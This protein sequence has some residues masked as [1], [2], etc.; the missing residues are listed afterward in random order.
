MWAIIKYKTNEFSV[1]KDSFKRILGDTPIFYNPKI[2]Y[3][4]YQNNKLKVYE[5][6]IL[7]NY[8]ICKHNKFNDNRII[9]LLKNSRGLSY[10]LNGFQLNQ[11]DIVK[12]VQHCKFHENRNG[13]LSQS[14]FDITK[15]NKVKFISG[16]FTQMFFNIIED[17]GK[18]IKGIINNIN[19][20]IS[21]KSNNFLFS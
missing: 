11:K 16:P 19:L 10:F 21:K 15:K 2:K 8:L 6:N 17:K 7:E 18:K 14:F 5:K 12:F 4:K 9:A 1:L 20:T 3:E 13:F